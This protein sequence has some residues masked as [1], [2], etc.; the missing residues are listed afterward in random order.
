MP[1]ARN[2]IIN[3][4]KLLLD[5]ETYDYASALTSGEG[6]TMSVLHQL[7]I[8]IMKQTGINIAPGQAIQISVIP[9][10]LNITIGA[11]K[12]FTPIERQCYFDD[13]ITLNHF[14]YWD[15]YR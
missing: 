12:R 7:D 5:A 15:D 9:T 6:F 14:P 11:K 8:P 1:Y 4:I 2:G 3:G 13:E 10:L